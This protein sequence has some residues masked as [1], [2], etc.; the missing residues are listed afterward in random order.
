[1]HIEHY[2]LL[3][4]WVGYDK[5]LTAIRHAEV[6]DFDVLQHTAQFD[7]L[8]TPIK[9]TGIAWQEEPLARAAA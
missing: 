8:L 7:L 3:L 5:H 2:F 6:R 1:M 4:S 9:L